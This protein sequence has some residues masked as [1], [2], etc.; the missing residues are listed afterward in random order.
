M[1]KYHTISGHF[2]LSSGLHSD[3]YVQLA[4][5]INDPFLLKIWSLNIAVG[6]RSAAP[7]LVISPAVG[8]IPFGLKIAEHLGCNFAWAERVNDKLQVKRFDIEPNQ[9]VVLVEDV[10]T[11]GSTLRELTVY[12]EDELNLTVVGR[13]AMVLRGAALP[14]W[15]IVPE[16]EDLNYLHFV[17]AAVW[18]AESCPLCAEEE[19]MSTP[20]SRRG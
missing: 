12:C 1:A 2:E 15:E 5:I 11:T 14:E 7:D 20:G 4:S 17:E 10:V 3:T 18:P 16:F 13:A 8:A 9:R 6:H 19:P